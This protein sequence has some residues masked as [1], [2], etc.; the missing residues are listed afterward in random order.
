[1]KIT[2]RK[3]Q[4][5]SG[6]L[7]ITLP[8]DW[9]KSFKLKKG[10][11]LKIQNAK[12]GTLTISP[13]DIHE[14]KK[15]K[16]IINY[17]KYFIRNF[18]RQYFLGYENIVVKFEAKDRVKKLEV[19]FVLKK[20]MNAQVIEEKE[21]KVLV[22][23]FKIDE[24]SIK[25]C[26]NRMFF[27]SMNAMDEL[28][29]DN[30]KE[31]LKEIDENVTKFYYMLVMQVRRYIDEGKFTEHNE[32]SL[33]HA[34]DCRMVAEK[35]KRTSEL[36]RDFPKI[37]DNKMSKFLSEV[38]IHYHNSYMY[39]YN[40]KFDKAIQL[41]EPETKLRLNILHFIETANKKKN[42]TL[43]EQAR[44]LDFIIGYSRNISMLTR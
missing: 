14:E 24:L 21:D 10:S 19:Y 35:I 37:S 6:S 39:F 33:L 12:N 4:E 42:L 31:I 27:L 40:H 13:Y 38:K 2:E 25:E 9:T 7:L 30:N 22:K 1:M 28:L 20:F 23:C 5:I 15:D 43:F 41:I 34:L 18:F 26:L 16:V 32:I 36:I 44:D 3:L 8:R 29:E 11:K 17:D